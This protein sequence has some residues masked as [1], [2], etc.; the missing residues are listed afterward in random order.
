MDVRDWEQASNASGTLQLP[1]L[2]FSALTPTPK[3]ME[4]LTGTR[5]SALPRRVSTR[6]PLLHRRNSSWVNP[7]PLRQRRGCREPCR[8]CTRARLVRLASKLAEQGRGPKQPNAAR[9]HSY[10]YTRFC[11]LPS[12]WNIAHTA[13]VVHVCGCGCVWVCVW[14]GVCVRAGVRVGV[15]RA[16]GCVYVYVY[17]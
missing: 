14:G 10:S 3:L 11:L 1:G 6:R 4:K 17:I 2:P 5:R 8:R 7:A 16:C 9:L 13:V 12:C 15:P